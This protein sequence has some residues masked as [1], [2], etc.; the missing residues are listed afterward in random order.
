MH[1]QTKM[2]RTNTC[3]SRLPSSISRRSEHNI[4]RNEVG[5]VLHINP[6]Y[7]SQSLSNFITDD[8]VDNLV[9]LKYKEAQ[10]RIDLGQVMRSRPYIGILVT[11]LCSRTTIVHR[12]SCSSS[13]G[14]QTSYQRSR[15]RCYPCS[16]NCRTFSQFATSR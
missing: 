15:G 2:D 12:H 7:L 6:R 8:M 16:T 13:Q 14:Q 10:G 9:R 1:L 3:S 5:P 4:I 11:C